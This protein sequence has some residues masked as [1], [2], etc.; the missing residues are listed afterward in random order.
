MN[1]TTPEVEVSDQSVEDRLAS[2]LEDQP[3]DE[4]PEQENAESEE[5]DQ[6]EADAPAEPEDDTEEVEYEGKAYKL[7]KELKEAVLRQADYTKKTQEV[8]SLRRQ[9]EDRQMFLQ[10]K[11]QLMTVAA[12]DLAEL[13]ALEKEAER[14]QALDWQQLHQTDPAQALGLM[15]RQQ[16]LKEQIGDLR[17]KLS[18]VAQHVQSATQQHIDR[19]WEAA[20]KGAR[21]RIGKFTLEDDKAALQQAVDLGFSPEEIKSKLADERLLLAVFK[22]AKW[23]ALQKA[24]PAVTKR[25]AEA[26]PM[27]AVSRSAP[28]AQTDGRAIEARERLRKTGDSNAAEALLERMFKKR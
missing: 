14:Y 12:N 5:E 6:E 24:K 26:R 2:I 17:G 7:P 27:K 16:S 11:E 1:D 20:V 28:Q 21:E 9:V 25:A 13:R 4:A 18:S 22:A 10:A 19:Q 23:D 3:E 8:A 15:Q